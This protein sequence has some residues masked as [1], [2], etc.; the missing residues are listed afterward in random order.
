MDLAQILGLVSL[1]MVV[2]VV[3]M[4][5]M[6]KILIGEIAV[7][8]VVGVNFL[9]LS[10][11]S[12]AGM[13]GVAVIYTLV[14]YYFNKKDEKLPTW[15]L[16]LFG[17]FFVGWGAIAYQDWRDILPMACSVLFVLAVM[18]KKPARYRF[19]KVFNSLL[20]LIYDV[21]IGAYTTCLTH[22]FLLA[23]GIAAIIQLDILE[24]RKN[25]KA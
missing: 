8:I 11:Y 25:N 13:N 17:A 22:F 21:L 15:I 2:F 3:Y 12:G 6:K 9:L 14:A 7:N 23:A 1:V 4:K 10:G 16:L 20:Y 18:Q 5:D 19:F 24:E